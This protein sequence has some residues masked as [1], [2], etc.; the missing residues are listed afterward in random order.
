M[1]LGTKFSS[2]ADVIWQTCISDVD[3]QD[4]L[5]FHIIN[6]HGIPQAYGNLGMSGA[7]QGHEVFES[8]AVCTLGLHM[9]R[10]GEMTPAS[11]PCMHP[12]A[13]LQLTFSNSKQHGVYGQ[14]I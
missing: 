3:W 4:F 5:F 8:R 11:I 14:S 6:T 10:Q 9:P 2:A 12:Q 1:W 13:Q 7:L